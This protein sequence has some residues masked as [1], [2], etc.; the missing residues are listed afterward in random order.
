MGQNSESVLLDLQALPSPE[1]KTEPADYG[2]LYSI[3][4]GLFD[5]G[6]GSNDESSHK[7]MMEQLEPG[8]R[9]AHQTNPK[10]LAAVST[11]Q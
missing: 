2:K 3:V 11:T 7:Q 9:Y 6:G 1:V 10:I 4:N 8:Q 5:S